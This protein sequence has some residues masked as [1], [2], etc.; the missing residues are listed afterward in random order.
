MVKKTSSEQKG[1]VEGKTR[2][3]KDLAVAMMKI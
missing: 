1:S 3:L 2:K